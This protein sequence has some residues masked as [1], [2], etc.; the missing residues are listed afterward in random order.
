MTDE[1]QYARILRCP[2]SHYVFLPRLSRIA[3][4][5]AASV[6]TTRPIEL[7]RSRSETELRN[8]SLGEVGLT[9]AHEK[10]KDARPE[11]FARGVQATSSAV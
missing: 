3:L 4:T 10:P 9:L 6:S 11:A 8:H 7:G 5:A 1:R 2:S